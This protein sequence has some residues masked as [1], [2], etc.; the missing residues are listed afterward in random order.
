VSYDGRFQCVVVL[1]QIRQLEGFVRKTCFHHYIRNAIRKQVYYIVVKTT[2]LTS[3]K[4]KI[5]VLVGC[6]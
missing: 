1:F 4:F 6:K 3:V 5:M 2:R